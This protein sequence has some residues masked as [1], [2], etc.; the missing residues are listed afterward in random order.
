[1]K[2]LKVLVLTITFLT[3]IFSFAS[4]QINGA[5]ASFPY[6]IYSKWFAEYNIVNPKI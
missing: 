2:N 6:P 3:P 5:G 4:V 1:M